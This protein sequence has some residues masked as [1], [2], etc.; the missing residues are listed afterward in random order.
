MGMKKNLLESKMKLHGDIQ[1]DLAEAIGISLQ[2]FNRKLN[3]ADGAEF[4]ES[5]IKTIRER[6]NLTDAEAVEIFLT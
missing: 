5:E 2:T 1:S 4:T 6:Y 3:G